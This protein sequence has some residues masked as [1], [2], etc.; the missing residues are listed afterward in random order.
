[1]IK[2]REAWSLV[3]TIDPSGKKVAQFVKVDGKKVDIVQWLDTF[4]WCDT[5][6]D[7][8]GI[9][10]P[11]DVY[12]VVEAISGVAIGTGFSEEEAIRDA[13]TIILSSRRKTIL[14]MLDRRIEKFGLS[15][16]YRLTKE[17]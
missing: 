1:V 15:P 16:A 13:Q 4:I 14:R 8:S 10:G 6:E 11:H 2:I 7:A 5:D 3:E 12:F 9:D 17:E